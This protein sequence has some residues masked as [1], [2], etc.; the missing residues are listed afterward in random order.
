LVSINHPGFSENTALVT[1]DRAAGG[2]AYLTIIPAVVF[3]LSEPYKRSSFV[4][5]NCW[6]SIFLFGAW[7]V[8]AA[9]AGIL[10]S[11]L[12]S[13]AFLTMSFLQMA[14]LGFFVLWLTVV[15]K[16]YGG[17]RVLLPVLGRLAEKQA[18]AK[19]E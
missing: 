13:A 8:A 5:F 7:L 4:R 17:K 15:V 12:P 3:L 19:P 2:V 18:G 10:Q 11:L 9:M 16:A 14:L 6:Q 1:S